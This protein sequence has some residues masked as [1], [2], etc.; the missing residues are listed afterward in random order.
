MR[1][2][3]NLSSDHFSAKACTYTETR[4]IHLSANISDQCSI[5]IGDFDN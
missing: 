5:P 2:Q 3:L 4:P 1:S